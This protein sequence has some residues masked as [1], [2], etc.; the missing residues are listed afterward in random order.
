MDQTESL[1]RIIQRERAARKAAESIIEIKSL[2][3]F[4]ANQELRQ[5]NE[6]LEARIEMRTAEIEASRQELMLAKEKA[7]AADRSKSEFLSN[8]S[9][10]IRTPLNAI[11]GL[12]DLIVR[13]SGDT[14]AQT[15]AR[16]I[17]FSAENLLVIIN[18]ILD[19]S[20]IEAGKLTFEAIP[21]S[22]GQVIEAMLQTFSA[23]AAEKNLQLR[24]FVAPETPGTLVGDPVKLSQVLI[25]LI[26]NALKF[27]AQ[28]HIHLHIR[29]RGNT[30]DKA[31]LCFC[32]EDTGIGIPADK[33]DLIFESFQQAN[34]S[35]TRHFGGTGLGLTITRRIIELQGGRIWVESIPGTGSRFQFELSFGVGQN[36]VPEALS[37]AR[38]WDEAAMARLRILLVEDIPM[39]Q[40]LVKQIFR[41]KHIQADIANHGQE[42][43]DLLRQ[44]AY[45]LVL[46]DLQMPVMDG[47]E[48]TRQIRLPG[49]GVLCPDVYI[50]ALTAD[51][52]QETRQEVLDI[53]MND[54]LTKPIRMDELYA[55]LHEVAELLGMTH[56]PA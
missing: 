24:A 52:F 40:F 10:E 34:T 32:V 33:L 5:L 50:I 55:K 3:L 8:M 54:F 4:M 44:K 2:E 22:L 14:Q 1:K 48:A 51:A 27:T 45:D 31:D 49:S 38:A 16:S 6:S 56:D 28:G 26:G 30:P 46:M 19:F 21:F 9:H 47:R 11:I 20:K 53:G 7:E 36:T 37:Q 42:A 18:E 17:Q 15:Y 43:L 35:T 12:T 39:N 23:K 25:N 41:R 29:V 13:D